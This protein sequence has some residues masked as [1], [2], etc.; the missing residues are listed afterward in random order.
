M[1]SSS[2]GAM[3]VTSSVAGRRQQRF[4]RLTGQ[5]CRL[6]GAIAPSFA[7]TRCSMLPN[8]SLCRPF[9]CT[10]AT[11]GMCGLLSR[12]QVLARR[13]QRVIALAAVLLRLRGT[14]NYT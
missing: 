13:W 1:R 3:R 12:Q 4:G 9:S 10:A 6:I 7:R 2:S 14:I 5:S 11:V 8:L